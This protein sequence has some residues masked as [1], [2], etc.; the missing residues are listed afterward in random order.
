[1]LNPVPYTLDDAIQATTRGL[2]FRSCD[3][4]SPL[5]SADNACRFASCWTVI[6]PNVVH[7]VM[8]LA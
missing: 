6:I 4:V 3:H 7:F 2:K 1:M 5:G 8:H